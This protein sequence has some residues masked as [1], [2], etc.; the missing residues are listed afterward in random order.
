LTAFA[1]ERPT[2]FPKGFRVHRTQCRAFLTVL[3]RVTKVITKACQR[4]IDERAIVKAQRWGERRR[5]RRRPSEWPPQE[6]AGC[7]PEEFVRTAA[8]HVGTGNLGRSDSTSV[9]GGPA[10]LITA[11]PIS[12]RT[13]RRSGD[14]RAKKTQNE[15]K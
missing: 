7:P 3:N 14:V 11:I 4:R 12:A 2:E 10:S 1:G 13:P 5:M 6:L 8:G 9:F 15:T